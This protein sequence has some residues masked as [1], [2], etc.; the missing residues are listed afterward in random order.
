M[1]RSSEAMVREIDALQGSAVEIE[2][3]MEEISGGINTINEGAKEVSNLAAATHASI[4]KISGI[5]NG[6]KV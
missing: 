2:T 1:N 6:F 5:A 3:R 4:E